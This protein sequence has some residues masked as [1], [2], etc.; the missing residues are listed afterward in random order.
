MSGGQLT[1]L[2]GEDVIKGGTHH[3]W[4][5]PVI[6]EQRSL[7]ELQPIVVHQRELLTLVPQIL[8]SVTNRRNF[9]KLCFCVI[10]E[11]NSHNMVTLGLQESPDITG[12]RRKRERGGERR[13]EK[14]SDF[15]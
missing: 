9:L 6:K 12:G 14:V 7:N 1:N 10:K 11:P 13:E 4:L 8:C 3:S 15:P 5:P 2:P